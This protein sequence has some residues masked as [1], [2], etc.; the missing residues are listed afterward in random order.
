MVRDGVLFFW[1]QDGL[2]VIFY[3]FVFGNLGF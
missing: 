2:E 3:Y 1:V